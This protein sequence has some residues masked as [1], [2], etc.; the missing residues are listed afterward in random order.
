MEIIT[1][2]IGECWLKS[3]DAVMENGA[4]VLDEDVNLKEVLSLTVKN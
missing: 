3:I 4:L 2:S 1:K